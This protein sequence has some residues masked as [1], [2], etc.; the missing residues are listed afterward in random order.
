[1]DDTLHLH[2]L[3]EPES[4][5]PPPLSSPTW[6]KWR[7][8]RLQQYINQWLEEALD[9]AWYPQAEALKN[10]PE[11]ATSLKRLWQASRHATL[12]GGKRIRPLLSVLV[13]QALSRHDAETIKGLCLSSE[14][15]HAQSL[16]FD[17]LPCMD[18]D[19][20]RRGKPT[21]H[22]AFD[23]ATAVLVGDALASFAF[24]CVVKYG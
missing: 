12:L 21:T 9:T 22:K 17:D 10:L 15:M 5:N 7:Y 4:G 11:L 16:V 1:M 13:W 23:E 14:F 24:E 8:G 6:L 19:D 18:D 2:H 20:L 3:L